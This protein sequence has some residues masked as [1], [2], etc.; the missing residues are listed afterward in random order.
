MAYIFGVP[1]HS[2]SGV[3]EDGLRSIVLQGAASLATPIKNELKANMVEKP[4][5]NRYQHYNLIRFGNPDIKAKS[6]E[7]TNLMRANAYR[8]A[9]FA[10]YMLVKPGFLKIRGSHIT[11]L[12]KALYKEFKNWYAEARKQLEAANVAIGAA[13]GDG[14]EEDFDENDQDAGLG[15]SPMALAV[16]G[17]ALIAVIALSRR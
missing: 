3:V 7:L 1:A 5:L 13:G 2:L 9:W 16:G 4:S 6:K 8:P 10:Y 15:I 17:A 12:N 11:K 14:A